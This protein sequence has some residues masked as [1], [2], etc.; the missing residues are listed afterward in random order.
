M[1]SLFRLL[2]RRASA[3]P[4]HAPEAI[5]SDPYRTAGDV[6][7]LYNMWWHRLPKVFCLRTSCQGAPPD[8]RYYRGYEPS[9]RSTDICMAC[10]KRDG[11]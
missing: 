5:D 11:R 6:G 1:R 9:K 3:Q 7:R 2:F 8:D 4:V 10:Y